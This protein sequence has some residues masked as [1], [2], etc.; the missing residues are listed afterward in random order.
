MSFD[1]DP[2]DERFQ[3]DQCLEEISRLQKRNTKLEAV[4]E[5]AQA[6]MRGATAYELD[7]DL[8]AALAALE[9]DE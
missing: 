3:L 1:I 2:K 9:A 6:A 5:A 8:V 7:D 4:A